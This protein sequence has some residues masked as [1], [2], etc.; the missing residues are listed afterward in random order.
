[1]GNHRFREILFRAA[2]WMDAVAFV[3]LGIVLSALKYNL[4]SVRPPT[5]LGALVLWCQN[6][7]LV[8]ITTLFAVSYGCRF[9]RQFLRPPLIQKQL[10]ALMDALQQE[11]F[12]A[13]MSGGASLYDHRVTLFRHG[14]LWRLH[15]WPWSGWLYPIERSGHMTR[16]RGTFFR[17]GGERGEQEGVAGQ[18]WTKSATVV[19]ENLPDLE[20][21]S[22]LEGGLQRGLVEE[23]AKRTWVSRDWLVRRLAAKKPMACS[24][25]GI[26]VEVGGKMWGVLVLDSRNSKAK[27]GQRYEATYRF[28]ARVLS[29]VLDPGG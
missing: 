21:V 17:A 16:R 25:C 18:A 26:P 10:K 7:G 29:K 15:R 12:R 9:I 5:V 11:V 28:F 4:S 22:S 3:L 14:W 27:A 2:L 24:F 19:V 1:M 23:Y 20:D 6:N 8:L 13:E